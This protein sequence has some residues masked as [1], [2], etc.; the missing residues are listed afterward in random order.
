MPLI[1]LAGAPGVGK[2][3]VQNVALE[4]LQ[5]VKPVKVA[6][7]G[8]YMFEMAQRAKLVQNRDEMRS[9]IP[10]E[11]YKELQQKAAEQIAKD[12]KDRNIIVNTH[13]SM[14]TASGLI[15]GLPLD[16]L[17]LL[18]PK[19]IVIVEADPEEIELRQQEDKARERS[20]FGDARKLSDFQNYS[21]SCAAAYSVIQN[22]PVKII[23]NKQG[24]I[25]DAAGELVEALKNAF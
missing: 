20:D 8:D 19:L 21:R 14:V 4:Q 7:F 2:S 23:L 12:A 10:R 22:V 16:I 5:T 25:R 3:T 13:L 15:P 6:T 24:K 9:K 18:N 17:K 11:K 1:I